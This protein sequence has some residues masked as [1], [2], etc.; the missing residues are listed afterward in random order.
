MVQVNEV[1]MKVVKNLL[2]LSA[3]C[4]ASTALMI[5]NNAVQSSTLKISDED[6]R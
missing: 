1:D 6:F 2:K 4:V 3:I 5:G